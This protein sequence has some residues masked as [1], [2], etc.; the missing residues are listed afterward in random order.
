MQSPFGRTLR[1]VLGLAR[2]GPGLLA[3]HGTAG[4][5]VALIGLVPLSTGTL[6]PCLVG[7]PF[8]VDVRGYTRAH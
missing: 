1:I 3:V 5:T 2:I 4:V 7:P 8:G 6:G